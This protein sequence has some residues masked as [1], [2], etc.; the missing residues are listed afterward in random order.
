MP[1]L[2]IKHISRLFSLEDIGG[3]FISL[4]AVVGFLYLYFKKNKLWQ[5]SAL[6]IGTVIFLLCFVVLA[7]RQHMM[8]FGF[9]LA[10]LITLGL[11]NLAGILNK[12]FNKTIFTTLLLLIVIYQMVLSAHIL[13]SRPYDGSSFLK[14][15]AY[16]EK[17]LISDVKSNDV[18]ATPLDAT[19]LDNLN[20]LSDK[21]LIK[22]SNQTVEKLLVENK[23]DFAF[24]EFK[25]TK[26]LGFS[27][28]MTEKITQQ[29]KVK[30]ITDNT[31]PAIQIPISPTKSLFMNLVK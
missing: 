2:L 23:L 12:Y 1:M 28:E 6:W 24:K 17:I 20:Y 7:Q 21:S 8:D 13:F 10:L 19:S 11:F 26:I 27:K 16:Q 31:L 14:L 29:T 3:P 9:I 18:I 30:N 25:V 5:F 15:K 22:F 4:L